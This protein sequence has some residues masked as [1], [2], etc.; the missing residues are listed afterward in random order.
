MPVNHTGGIQ[1]SGRGMQIPH[2][3]RTNSEFGIRGTSQIEKRNVFVLLY[4]GFDVSI[5]GNRL[6]Y[7]FGPHSQAAYR[8]G[9]QPRATNSSAQRTRQHTLKRNS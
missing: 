4:E 6:N 8:T 5:R 2:P 9:V 7:D 3:A 1:L